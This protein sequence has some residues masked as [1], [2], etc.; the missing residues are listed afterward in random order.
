MLEIRNLVVA[1]GGLRALHDVIGLLIAD[2]FGDK[3]DTAFAG[4]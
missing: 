1:Y 4:N 2:D 3:F